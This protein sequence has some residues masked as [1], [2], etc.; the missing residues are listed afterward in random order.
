MK[1]IFLILSILSLIL[2]V[3][4]A[5]C[6]ISYDKSL[7]DEEKSLMD[8]CMS[9]NPEKYIEKQDSKTIEAS[10]KDVCYNLVA[11]KS[12]N[13]DICPLIKNS[14]LR[15]SCYF[16]FAVSMKNLELCDKIKSSSKV[17]CKTLI[18]LRPLTSEEMYDYEN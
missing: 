11:K 12:R 6:G 3:F 4:I 10:E 7:T 17:D 2:M 9:S 14:A 1:K 15:D 18:N 5:G 13:S 8:D 16:D